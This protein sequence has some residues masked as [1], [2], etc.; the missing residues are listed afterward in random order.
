MSGSNPKRRSRKTEKRSRYYPY[1]HPLI[2]N[3]MGGIVFQIFW[4]WL[5]PSNRGDPSVVVIIWLP[6]ILA[7]ILGICVYM[8]AKYLLGKSWVEIGYKTENRYLIYFL[9]D[10]ARDVGTFAIGLPLI[11]LLIVSILG[12]SVSSVSIGGLIFSMLVILSIAILGL[13]IRRALEFLNKIIS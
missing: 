3:T 12:G 5:K 7:T 2:D 9:K 10:L 4:N 13:I 1:Y 8:V 6:A 11:I